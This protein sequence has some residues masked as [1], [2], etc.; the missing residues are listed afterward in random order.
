[1][2]EPETD[3]VFELF[4]EELPHGSLH[5]EHGECRKIFNAVAEG[6]RNAG[7]GFTASKFYLT[8]R[9]IAG[10]FS[11]VP[12]TLAAQ[13][14][15]HPG[16]PVKIGFKDGKPTPALKGFLKKFL[17]EGHKPPETLAAIPQWQNDQNEQS[18]GGNSKASGVYRRNE[19]AGEVLFYYEYREARSTRALIGEI[20]TTAFVGASFEKSMYWGEKQGPFLRPVRSI[21]SLLGEE[22]VAMTFLGIRSGNTTEGH[23]FLSNGPGPVV[24]SSASKYQEILNN[25]K[26]I[27]DPDERL[28]LILDGIKKIET[29]QGL[30]AVAV[31]QVAQICAA[32]TEYPI[33]VLAEV[34]PALIN[35]PPEVV[36]Q[37]MIEHQKYFPTF[38]NKQNNDN[39]DSKPELSNTFIF[40]ANGIHT[41]TVTQ[42]NVN[43]LA[44]R[45]SDGIFLY[46][47][48]LKTGLS[49]M[50]KKS[51]KILFEQHL[52]SY[53]E[54]A[55]R[56]FKIIQVLAKHSLRVRE[57]IA[58]YSS[59]ELK[60]IVDLLKSDLASQM[61]FEFPHLQ[62]IMGKYYVEEA[63]K[64]AQDINELN[65][66]GTNHVHAEDIATTIKEHYMPLSAKGELPSNPLGVVMSLAENLDNLLGLF[67]VG[68]FPTGSNDPYALRRQGY[69]AVRLIIENTLMLPLHPLL[70]ELGE[71]SPGYNGYIP[72]NK[73]TGV[74]GVRE[75]HK[76]TWLIKLQEFILSRYQTFSK[77]AGLEIDETEAGINP[78]LDLLT[79][80]E[81]SKI[82]KAERE[83]PE[84]IAL[85]H[86]LKRIENISEDTVKAEMKPEE[87][88][89]SVGS[90]VIANEH[91]QHLQHFSEPAELELLKVHEQ[92]VKAV[93]SI[94]S[95]SLSKESLANRFFKLFEQLYTYNKPL[96]NFFEQVFINV[97]NENVK[98]ARIFLLLGVKSQI[99]Q[100][101]DPRKVQVK[102]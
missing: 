7:I 30:K 16:P 58:G 100:I 79:G 83:K 53:G 4:C 50:I 27:V 92:I 17:P 89:D 67:A 56:L 52:G 10:Y 78:N 28:A 21:L 96:N 91:K 6:F 74:A 97:D 32:L 63:I 37:E 42:G 48:D 98:R 101:F 33:P 22:V 9:R 23:R 55:E 54:K 70:K 25:H 57:I 20:L 94:S 60:V 15:K 87:T 26:V 93:S 19:S 5:P 38:K 80:F 36:M 66:S 59:A 14:I 75:N 13:E 2:S 29:Q 43:V 72:P 95:I 11:G 99:L 51:H 39:N 34:D 12:T 3:F 44:S 61:V 90:I 24:I 85:A 71:A 76:G 88:S 35:I 102:L 1:M 18:G 64:N 40:V 69:A 81:L 45:L 73:V 82:I 31:N 77:D 8:P 46:Q 41:P 68:L 86:A 62:G 49:A 84:F 65:L 47:E